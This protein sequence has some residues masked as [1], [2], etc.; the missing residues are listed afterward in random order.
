MDFLQNFNYFYNKIGYSLIFKSKDMKYTTN[1]DMI[2]VASPYISYANTL[3]V[4][5]L[6]RRTNK[7]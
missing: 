4:F 2:A 3:L 1:A 5:E 6:S 7:R